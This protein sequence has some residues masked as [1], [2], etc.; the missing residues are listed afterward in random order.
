MSV[1]NG[2][3]GAIAGPKTAQKIQKPSSTAAG[4]ERLRTEKQTDALA[5]GHRALVRLR[6][7]NLHDRG[8]LGEENL[9]LG[10]AH[11]SVASRMRGLRIE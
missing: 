1:V 4:E 10:G 8:P 3:S 9:F 7:R 5:A 2:L 6:R 11:G